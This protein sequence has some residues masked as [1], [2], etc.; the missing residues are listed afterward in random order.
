MNTIPENW[1]DSKF[2]H[3][4][5]RHMNKIKLAP[6]PPEECRQDYKKKRAREG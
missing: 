4:W 2:C 5:H 6:F 1:S 3:R